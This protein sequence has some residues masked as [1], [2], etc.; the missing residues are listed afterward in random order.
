M[1]AENGAG[2][3]PFRYILVLLGFVE[4]AVAWLCLFTNKRTLSLGL[5]AWLTTTLVAYRI[6]LWTMAWPHPAPLLGNLMGS[7]NISPLVADGLVAAI[8]VCLLIGSSATFC[9]AGRAAKFQRMFC[10]SCGGKIQFA[11]QNLGRKIPCPLCK[12]TL[13]LR[14]PE[15]L[16]MACSFCKYHIEFPAHALGQ[17]IPCP[18][19][20][21]TVILKEPA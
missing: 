21:M 4:M 13:T 14:A 12:T 18:H 9:F 15:N 19:C 17:R 6:G 2:G 10:P 8:S 11:S 20:N 3:L 1:I 7:L 5:V 16:K